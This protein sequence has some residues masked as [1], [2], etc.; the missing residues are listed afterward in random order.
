MAEPLSL[1]QIADEL[2]A[3]LTSI[4]R[5]I[6]TAEQQEGSDLATAI[7]AQ[8][9]LMVAYRLVTGTSWLGRELQVLP[10]E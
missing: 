8:Y 3:R 1:Q 4:D 2:D 6:D 7:G 5:I 10:H 9:G